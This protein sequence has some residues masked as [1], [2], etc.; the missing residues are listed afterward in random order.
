[1]FGNKATGLPNLLGKYVLF[2][3]DSILTFLGVLASWPPP[4]KSCKQEPVW[5]D[6]NHF[7][8]FFVSLLLF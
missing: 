2:T 7:L 6:D 8:P 5:V 1:M 4:Y 3:L